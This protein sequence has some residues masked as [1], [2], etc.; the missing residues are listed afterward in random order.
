ML[1][2]N[3]LTSESVNRT[4][5]PVKDIIYPSNFDSQTMKSNIA[6]ALLSFAV[7][8][9]SHIHPVFTYPSCAPS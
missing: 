7:N 1:G 4:L 2:D 3:V 9:S 8:C 6:L 5:V